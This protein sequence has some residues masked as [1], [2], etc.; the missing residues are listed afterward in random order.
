MEDCAQIAL[1]EHPAPARTHQSF[2]GRA[3]GP[4]REESFDFKTLNSEA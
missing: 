1:I 3:E 2:A 4:S